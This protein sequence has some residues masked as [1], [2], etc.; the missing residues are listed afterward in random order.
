MWAISPGV[1]AKDRCGAAVPY[2][3]ASRC[4]TRR[5]RYLGLDFGTANGGQYATT[6]WWRA[7]STTPGSEKTVTPSD[8]N[9]TVDSSRHPGARTTRPAPSF[10]RLLARTR[11]PLART[12][13]PL[14]RKSDPRACTAGPEACTT[15]P[16][17]CKRCPPACT[18]APIACTSYPLSRTNGPLARTSDALACR[19]GPGT[20][21]TA[22]LICTGC[23][24]ACNS[25]SLA[26]TSDHLACT[27]EP[28]TR[29]TDP[30]T[31]KTRPLARRRD[32]LPCRVTPE[33]CTTAPLVCTCAP[34]AC[35]DVHTIRAARTRCI[36]R[37]PAEI[38]L[39]SSA[40][41]ANPNVRGENGFCMK[42]DPCSSK[43]R[44]IT[45]SSV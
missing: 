28:M 22:L 13:G 16:P 40:R 9:R 5:V 21:T 3:D 27:S 39:S 30:V 19:A 35:T 2:S 18:S 1:P 44:R 25:A 11:G 26:S 24:L 41:T 6:C 15:A 7:A 36:V 34:P 23:P 17:I 12:P 10:N 14:P 20:C 31:R 8:A 33:A 42:L 4:C 37:Q 45:S 29:T 38:A 43:P 32:S